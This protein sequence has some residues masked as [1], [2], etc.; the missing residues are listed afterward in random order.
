MIEAQF[1]QNQEFLEIVARLLYQ[2]SKADTVSLSSVRPNF[3][4]TN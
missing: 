2:G 1:K 4:S 3:S